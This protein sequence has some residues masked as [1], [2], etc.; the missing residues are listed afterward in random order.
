MSRLAERL[1]CT[2]AAL[3]ETAK[4]RDAL[5]A[6]SGQMLRLLTKISENHDEYI[7]QDEYG[8]VTTV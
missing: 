8:V 2:T 5:A 6:D 1:D 3:L 4:Q 7:N